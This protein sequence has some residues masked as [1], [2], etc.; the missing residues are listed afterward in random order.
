MLS[1]KAPAYDKAAMAIDEIIY[2][3]SQ[4]LSAQLHTLREKLFPP[5]AQKT[6]RRFTSTEAARLIGVTDS[7]LGART[8]AAQDR[9]LRSNGG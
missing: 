1:P 5:E 9:T 6:L 2:A 8:R 4:A 3:D 7:Y